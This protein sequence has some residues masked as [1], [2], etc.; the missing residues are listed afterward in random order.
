M[1]NVALFQILP[2][3]FHEFNVSLFDVALFDV[4]LF[5]AALF[6]VVLSKT[7]LC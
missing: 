6:T 2:L 7:A 1:F 4:A 5:I 3:M